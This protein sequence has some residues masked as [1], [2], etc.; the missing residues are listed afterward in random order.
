M[1]SLRSVLSCPRFLTQLV[2]AALTLPV[3]GFSAAI[4]VNGTCKIGNCTSPGSLGVGQSS[5][6]T[7]D[8]NYT[9]GNGDQYNIS[10]FYSDHYAPQRLAFDPTVIYIG[11]K[12]NPLAASI[13]GDTV[14]LVML[15][16]FF[17]PTPGV[18]DGNYC[19]TF[20]FTV[21]AGGTAT[22]NTYFDNDGVGL[23][24][25]NAGSST[26]SMCRNIS[27][28]TSQNL[29]DYMDTQMLL[30]FSFAPGSA[31]GATI[32]SAA[33]EPAQTLPAALGLAAFALVV[34]RSRTPRR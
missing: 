1:K 30:N 3:L 20:P 11:N 9:F 29:S 26:Q 27:F 14:S 32:A 24:T 22:G 8:F 5:A 15:E 21:E 6:G 12:G 33:P 13:G 28:T 2:L 10:G 4:S 34:W 17:D 18:W 25:G 16:N 31:P 19:E 7:F 23:L